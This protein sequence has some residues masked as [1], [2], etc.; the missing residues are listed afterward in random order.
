MFYKP[1]FIS[2][3][4]SLFVFLSLMAVQLTR[5]NGISGETS[6][7]YDFKSA[8]STFELKS[9]ETYMH[10]QEFPYL[11]NEDGTITLNI[12]ASCLTKPIMPPP[13]A[14]PLHG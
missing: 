13:L 4:L 3:S 10:Q 12:F 14:S 2:L 5:Y 8:H 1:L 7:F 9:A 6:L 11:L